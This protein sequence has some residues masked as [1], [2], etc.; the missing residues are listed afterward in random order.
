[1][2]GMFW[3]ALFV[4]ALAAGGLVWYSAKRWKE[5]QAGEADRMAAFLAATTGNRKPAEPAP[6]PA[7]APAAGA[8]ADGLAQ[9]KLLFEAAHK[10]GEAGEPA[11]SIQLYARLLARFPASG[12]AEQARARVE[13][14]KKRLAKA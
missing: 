4:I 7:A 14:E 8:P 11:L 9:Q 13:A 5:R 2:L 10:A 3:I 6:A 12:F 1:M